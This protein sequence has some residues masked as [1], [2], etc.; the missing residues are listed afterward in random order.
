[1]KNDTYRETASRARAELLAFWCS[2]L[3]RISAVNF[4]IEPLTVLIRDWRKAGAIGLSAIAMLTFAPLA[5]ASTIIFNGDFTNVGGDGVNNSLA[6]SPVANWTSTGYNF[7]FDCTTSG[8]ST[9]ASGADTANNSGIQLWGPANGSSNGLAASPDGAN[10]L[11]MDGAYEV[12]PVSQTVSGLTVGDSYT[13]N[14]YYAGAQQEGY[15]GVTTEAFIVD[16]ADTA[17]SGGS[18][19]SCS[20]TPILTNVNHGF[21]GW[22]SSSYTF[23]ATTASG[24]LS[25]LAQGT[26]NGEP[27][28]TLLDG[29]TITDD[30]KTTDPVPEP[31]T[32]C[33]VFGGLLIGVGSVISKTRPKR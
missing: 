3:R 19:S 29:V 13:V 18:C 27:P 14:F 10:F 32:M 16:F 8:T 4:R 17:Y 12:G 21:T 28:F 2:R 26:P 1:M 33:L 11:A 24:V 23:V 15:N 5:T 9:C 6:N 31:G 20:E 7:V 25:F 30:G 22:Y